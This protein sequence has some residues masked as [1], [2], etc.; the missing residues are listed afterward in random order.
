MTPALKVQAW[1]LRYLLKDEFESVNVS[2]SYP[3]Q[4][5][6][7]E[8]K[9]TTDLRLRLT[10]WTGAPVRY[11]FGSKDHVM[12]IS[13]CT[14]PLIRNLPKPIVSLILKLHW[15]F[16]LSSGADRD[17]ASDIDVFFEGRSKEYDED[18]LLIRRIP[19][20]YVQ[21]IEED[22]MVPRS[23]RRHTCVSGEHFLRYTL[24]DVEESF[25]HWSPE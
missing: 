14:H 4:I 24:S 3:R 23:R 8:Y 11:E 5:R 18:Y 9:P 7:Q 16:T 15:R 19:E 12:L 25:R 22:I 13:E 21:T 17:L 6:V 1:R 10:E 20:G 2:Y